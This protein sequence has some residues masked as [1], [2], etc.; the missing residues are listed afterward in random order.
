MLVKGTPSDA[1]I[2]IINS[3][4]IEIYKYMYFVASMEAVNS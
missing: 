4:G 3:L 2:Q 1:R